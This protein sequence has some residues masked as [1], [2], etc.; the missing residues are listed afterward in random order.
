MKKYLVIKRY[1]ALSSVVETSFDV[2]EDA[3]QYARLCEV[4]DDNKYEYIVAEVLQCKREM[5]T[6]QVLSPLFS[7][8]FFACGNIK[9]TSKLLA[10]EEEKDVDMWILGTVSTRIH[11][12]ILYLSQL[13][14]FL[15]I[16][17]FS[18]Y[19]HKRILFTINYI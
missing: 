15:N 10:E 13:S 4:R 6:R 12:Y 8:L 17:L 16:Q 11:L 14:F 3:F 7:C 9:N 5:S 19:L 18:Y 1:K 2:K